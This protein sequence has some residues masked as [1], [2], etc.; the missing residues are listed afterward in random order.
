MIIKELTKIMAILSNGP[1][2]GFSGKAGS[3]VGYYQHGKWVIRGLPRL[4]EK[5]KKGSVDQNICR[6][7]FKKMQDFLGPIIAH[8]RIGFNLE[9]KRNNNTAHNSAKSWNMLNAFDENGE[10]N[11]SAFRFSSGNLPVPAD[12]A[13]KVNEEG[14]EFTWT[15]DSTEPGSFGARDLRQDDQVMILVYNL[16]YKHLAGTLSGS[17]RSVGREIV[18]ID[19]SSPPVDYHT[20]ISFISDDRQSIANSVYT[21]LVTL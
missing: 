10:I 5:N 6:S 18:E 13:V 8:I 16:E 15:D 14:L 3:I 21:G 20:W 17:K 19:R 4:S 1:N 12:A 11:C 7:R 2:G 9:A